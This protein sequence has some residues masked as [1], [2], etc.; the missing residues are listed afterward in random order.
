[1]VTWQELRDNP[2]A[3][4]IIEKRA[5]IIKGTR[6][7][8]WSEGFIETTTPTAV[9]KM[10]Q[11]KYLQ[12]MPVTFHDPKGVAHQFFLVTSPES[13]L[14]KI[15][16]GGF[17]KIFEICQVY[18]DYENFGHRHNPEFTMLEWYRAPGTIEEIMDDTEN[19]FKSIARAINTPKIFFNN[20]TITILTQWERVSMKE[21]WK[22]YVNVNLDEYLTN[23][24]MAQ[25]ALAAGYEINT[26]DS[27]EDN[28]YK[29]FL[30]KIEPHLGMDKPTLV[31]DYPFPM[32]AFCRKKPADPRYVERVELYIG[33]L[34]LANGYGELVDGEEQEK[35]MK[36]NHEFR[37]DYGSVMAPIDE[38]FNAAVAHMPSAGGIALGVD[39]M[40]MLFTGARDINEVIFESVG[41]QVGVILKNINYE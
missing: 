5:R 8:F 4:E 3:R 20:K 18:R 24:S 17:N 29:I 31:Y 37:K 23:E 1:M 25:L 21:L 7:F 27:Y 26:K 11:E 38:D 36:E 13:G 15:L 19:M 6:E 14:K 35:R 10:I 9:N 16:A 34:E 40:V 33:G 22:K 39:R 32:S 30:N 12:P 41:D 28:F 2:K